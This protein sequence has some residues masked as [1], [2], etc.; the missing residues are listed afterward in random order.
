M[1]GAE[2]ILYYDC[3]SGICGDMNLAALVDL[4]VPEDHLRAELGKLGLGGWRLRFSPDSKMGIHGTRADVDLLPEPVKAGGRAGLSSAGALPSG[5]GLSSAGARPGLGV[6]APSAAAHAHAHRAY[7]DIKAMISGSALGAGI[8]ER[9][10]AIFARL[11]E[12][13]AKVHRAPVEDVGFHEVGAV[14]SIVDIV[15]AAVCL[16]YLAPD[17]VICSTVELGGGF[18]KCQHGLLPVPAPAVVE[19]MR[20]KPVKSGA[21]A[22]ETTTPTGAAILAASVDEWSDDI[23][24]RITRTGYGV[25]HRDAEIPNLLRVHLGERERA[26]AAQGEAQGAAPLPPLE[27]AVLLECNIDD[28]SPELHGRLIE[29][30]MGAGA[31]DAWLTPIVM[32]KSR[33][34]VTLSALCAPEAEAAVAEVFYRETTTFGLRR[35]DAAKRPLR[36]EIRT[37]ETSLGAVRVKTAF[38]G[39]EALKSKP[40]YEDLRK[41]AEERGM[42]LLEVQAVV[43]KEIGKP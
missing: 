5:A 3:F 28:M 42:A 1:E 40:E 19:L 9:A 35:T 43:L 39:G 14:D 37:V 8:K 41:I 18:V 25:G 34:A 29:R 2:R 16:D 17:R 23:R 12:A 20:E 7:R 38:L 10:L 21:A 26:A 32:K 33:A 36:R 11:A 13:E 31:V 24:F 6:A 22:M 15:G 30:L 27:A 4:G